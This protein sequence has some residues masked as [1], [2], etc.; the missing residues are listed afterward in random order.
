MTTIFVG[1]IPSVQS[2]YKEFRIWEILQI[3]IITTHIFDRFL[4]LFK[5]LI[6]GIGLCLTHWSM[7]P[8]SMDIQLL[9][10]G[11]VSA[12]PRIRIPTPFV[13]NSH[14]AIHTADARHTVIS[15]PTRA[16]GV[17]SQICSLKVIYFGAS[18]R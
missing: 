16:L 15:D 5:S 17:L 6:C 14:L 10:E 9:P 11:F 2:R 7:R 1:S 18:R 3:I 8:V 12:P 13:V 4:S